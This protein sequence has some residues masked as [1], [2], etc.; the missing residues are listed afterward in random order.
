MRPSFGS[1]NRADEIVP[2]DQIVRPEVHFEPGVEFAEW[3]FGVS[4]AISLS[5]P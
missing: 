4:E 2:L 3:T 1:A 5:V